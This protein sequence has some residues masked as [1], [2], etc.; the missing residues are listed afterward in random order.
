MSYVNVFLLALGMSKSAL[1]FV[2]VAGPLSGLIMQPVVGVLSDNCQSKYGRRRPFMLG[3]SLLVSMG[4]CTLAW[5]KEIGGI[6]GSILSEGTVQLLTIFLAVVSVFVTDF[7]VNAVQACCRALIVD[8]LPPDKQEHG[9]GWA[10]R[11]I[12]VGHL[13]GYFTGYLDLVEL[14]NGF[15]GDTQLKSLVV[16]ASFALVGC[17]LITCFSV[18]ERV[19]TKSRPNHQLPSSVIHQVSDIFT[20]LIKNVKSLPPRIKQILRVQLFA[21][22]GWFTFLFYSS[23]WVSEV[24][25]KYDAGA[26]AVT[27]H[28]ELVGE[29]ARIGSRSLMCFSLVTL[30][31]S[32]ALPEFLRATKSRF[33]NLVDLWTISHFVYATMVF[34]SYYVTSTAKATLLVSV[35][36]F[37]WAITTWA[38]F[39]LLGTEILKLPPQPLPSDMY[40]HVPQEEDIELGE[41]ITVAPEA[42]FTHPADNTTGEQSGVYLGIHNVA[43]TLP[44]FVSTCMSFLIFSAITDEADAS[45]PEKPNEGDGGTAIARTLQ[46]GAI[47]AAIAGILT[48]KLKRM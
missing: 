44:Q 35:C 2:W 11:M 16:V 15:L 20:T 1:S 10:G 40:S 30:L 26:M 23:T 21:W 33:I 27:S 36:G 31:C 28:S 9:N 34:L 17:V 48:M 46:V 39:A 24:Y 8:V 5:S 29:L 22:Y 32:L 6:F 18:E 42:A 38:P 14:F 47:T 7:A 25:I 45:L 12:A 4:L 37:S 19:L 41:R 43:I 13:L 3:G